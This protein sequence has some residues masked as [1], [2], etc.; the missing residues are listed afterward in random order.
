MIYVKENGRLLV[1]RL[2]ENYAVT[3]ENVSIFEV[4]TFFGTAPTI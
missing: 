1:C 3:P 4:I 2:E